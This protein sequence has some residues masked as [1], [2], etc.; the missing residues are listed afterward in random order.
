MSKEVDAG[1]GPA[2][3]GLDNAPASNKQLDLGQD[4]A[5]GSSSVNAWGNEG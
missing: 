4:A 5:H 1:W 3:A 2:P